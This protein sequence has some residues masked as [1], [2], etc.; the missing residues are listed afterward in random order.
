M[1]DENLENI[2]FNFFIINGKND[3]EA[4]ILNEVHN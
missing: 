3:E 4:K 2:N 1:A